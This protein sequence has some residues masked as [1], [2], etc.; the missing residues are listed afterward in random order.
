MNAPTDPLW[1]RSRAL[2]FTLYGLLSLPLCL[3]D[4][5]EGLILLGLI[6]FVVEFACFPGKRSA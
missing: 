3:F 4:L 1:K 6:G 5:Y 2:R